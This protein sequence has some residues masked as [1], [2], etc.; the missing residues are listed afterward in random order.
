LA[1]H[2][3]SIYPILEVSG[4]T[5][6]FQTKNNW[7]HAVN[8]LSFKLLKGEVLGVVGESGCGKS[9]TCKA[10][11]QLHDDGVQTGTVRLNG[12]DISDLP[13]HI[14]NKIRGKRIAMVFQDALSSLNP[15]LSIGRQI[16]EILRHHNV[17]S[18]VDA[19]DAAISMLTRMGVQD[20]AQRLACYPHQQS[21]G[22]NQRIVIAMALSCGPEVLLADEPT[23]ALDPTIQLQIHDLF[24]ELKGQ[25]SILL[26]SHNLGAIRD[27]AD[28]V[29]IMYRGMIVEEQPV[30][31]FF[32]DPKHPYSKALLSAV[33]FLGRSRIVL[34]GEPPQKD[35]YSKGCPF[36]DR[37]LFVDENHCRQ[38]L[39]DLIELDHQT[40]VRCH[41]AESK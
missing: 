9:V 18:K 12:Q 8:D 23:A 38:K 5:V 1:L 31:P 41:Y 35:A 17:M 21:G 29:I 25:L 22:I 32:S 34:P 27:L 28:R 3:N 10:I 6:K 7:F 39:P 4:L 16:I 40:K 19:R 26:V 24:R 33:P 37:C 2:M 11:M 13:D 15:V 20:A 30:D 36:A 14:L